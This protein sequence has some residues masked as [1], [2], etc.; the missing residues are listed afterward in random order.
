MALG[1]DSGRSGMYPRDMDA[2]G[3]GD[4]WLGFIVGLIVGAGFVWLLF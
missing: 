4:F 3:S 1:D 2:G